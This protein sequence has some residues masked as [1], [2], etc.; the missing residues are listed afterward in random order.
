M[1]ITVNQFDPDQ[2]REYRDL[3][4]RA[5]TDAP[6]AF[7]STIEQSLKIANSKWQQRLADINPTENLP[8]YTA[9]GLQMG[10]MSWVSIEPQERDQAHLFQMWVAPEFRGIGAAQGNSAARALYE[11]AGFVATG[12]TEPLRPGSNLNVDEMILRFR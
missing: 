5:L 8:L 3:R 11:T 1:K 10:G 12:M 9:S 7:G 6:D 4:R 2:W